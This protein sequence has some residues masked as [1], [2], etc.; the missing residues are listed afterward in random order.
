MGFINT[1]V[2]QKL[3]YTCVYTYYCTVKLLL[4]SLCKKTKTNLFS[5]K[6][7]LDMRKGGS[8]F[9]NINSHEYGFLYFAK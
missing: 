3:M 9:T 2:L 5:Q 8:I 1:H 7:L 4:P 6:C